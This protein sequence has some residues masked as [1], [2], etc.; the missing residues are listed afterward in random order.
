MMKRRGIVKAVRPKIKTKIKK[1]LKKAGV[2][3]PVV[4][5]EARILSEEER[6]L[7]NRQKEFL[8]VKGENWRK[9]FHGITDVA[10]SFLPGIGGVIGEGAKKLFGWVTGLGSYTMHG[11]QLSDMPPQVGRRNSQSIKITYREF[12]TNL[13]SSASA[14]GTVSGSLAIQP[15]NTLLFPWLSNIAKNYQEW[16]PCGMLFEF[17]TTSSDSL[18]STNTALGTVAMGVDYDPN[19]PNP[20]SLQEIL[21]LDDSSECKPSQSFLVPVECKPRL[22]TRRNFDIFIN[23]NNLENSTLGNLNY[24]ITGMQGTSVVVGQLWV[25]YCVE[26]I[27]PQLGLA[28]STVGVYSNSAN[29]NDG[30]NT[31]PKKWCRIQSKTGIDA[32]HAFGTSRMV[33]TDHWNVGAI[34]SLGFPTGKFDN[35][36]GKFYFPVDDAGSG[37]T[38]SNSASYLIGFV[39]SAPSSSATTISLSGSGMNTVAGLG[40][41]TNIGQLINTGGAAIYYGTWYW[42]GI[43]ANP[44]IAI[45]TTATSYTGASVDYLAI[46]TGFGYLD[47]NQ[48]VAYQD[49]AEVSKLIS[50]FRERVCDSSFVSVSQIEECK[51]TVPK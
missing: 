41:D 46:R 32:T 45:T 1:V 44:Y 39:I 40:G 11:V 17:K 28:S 43:T 50:I 23:T 35:S 18:N 38:N 27:K 2:P 36:G 10:T 3:A 5:A 8:G 30:W 6:H 14:G 24:A 34:D 7:A 20:T 15:Q 49:E 26:L 47:Y 9:G 51:S 25:T 12:V 16:R 4:R 37:V 21:M 48:R 31:L 33:N 13:V 22:G 42:D 19:A 29:G